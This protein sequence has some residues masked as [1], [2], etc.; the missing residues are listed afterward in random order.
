MKKFNQIVITMA[1]ILIT[2]FTAVNIVHSEEEG[3]DGMDPKWQMMEV[4]FA[5]IYLGQ[6]IDRA[7]EVL[8]MARP[9]IVPHLSK[10]DNK[11]VQ[12]SLNE[13][14]GNYFSR[15]ELMNWDV[16]GEGKLINKVIDV[17]IQPG[18]YFGDQ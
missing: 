15:K 14:E 7:L 9:E 1:I 8:K 4:G 17:D 2:L 12:M 18:D 10:G 5:G 3:E 6:P 16:D 11:E 13:I